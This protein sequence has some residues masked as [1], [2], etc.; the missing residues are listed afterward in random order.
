M[1]TAMAQ[2]PQL[3][4]NEIAPGLYQGSFP[5]DGTSLR[6]FQVLVLCAEELQPRS[7]E[8][9]HVNEVI[10]APLDDGKLDEEQV[11]VA[12]RAAQRV[13]GH[14]R[15][16]RRVLVTCAMGRNRS[17]LVCALALLI[18]CP[19]M[20]GETAV[21]RIRSRRCGA[22]VNPYFVDFLSRLPGARR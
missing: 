13:A 7:A 15:A 5:E 20:E 1:P 12:L 3:D 14:L 4:A 22:L 17:G 18:L 9:P 21:K 11:G 2:R 19:S 16:R 6:G 10:H 8:F